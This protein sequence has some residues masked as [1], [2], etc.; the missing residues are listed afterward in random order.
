[1]SQRQELAIGATVQ[2]TDGELGQ[3]TDVIVNPLRRSVTHVVVQE[4]TAGART[5]VVP[6]D[7]ITGTTHQTVRLR[8]AFAELARFPEFRVVH[9]VPAS[10]PEAALVVEAQEI[11]ADLAVSA[12]TALYY[13]PYVSTTEGEVA[14]TEEHIPAGEVSFSRGARIMT[15]DGHEVGAVEEFLLNPQ[16]ETITHVIARTG[17]LF[18]AHEIAIPIAAVARAT[19]DAVALSL[20]RAEVGGLPAVPV[21]RHYDW[22]AH[23]GRV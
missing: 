9:Y 4:R 3:L 7:R 15:R 2:G 5:F 8:C 16:N 10:A 21:R 20:T 13:A 12:G 18:L 14:V 6:V 19:D 1:M 17:H 23:E 11:D 22:A